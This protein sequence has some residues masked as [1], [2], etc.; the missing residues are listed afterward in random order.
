MGM[1]EISESLCIGSLY[2][3]LNKYALKKKKNVKHFTSY[4]GE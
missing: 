1:S 4:G 3:R 2:I